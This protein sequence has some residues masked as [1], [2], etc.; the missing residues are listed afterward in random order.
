M[1]KRQESGHRSGRGQAS[2]NRRS[3]LIS[4][5]VEHAPDAVVVLECSEPAECK[6]VYANAAFERLYGVTRAQV[7]GK[8]LVAVLPQRAPPQDVAR[9]LAGLKADA[10]FR[11]LHRRIGMQGNLL[12]LEVIYEPYRTH[13][14]VF[15]VGVSRDMTETVLTQRSSRHLA[16]A[17]DEA[18][19]AIAVSIA[20]ED[21][22][23]FEY[24]NRAFTELLG[25]ETA[26]LVGRSWRSLYA[27]ETDL[28]D[29]VDYRIGL[30]TGQKVRGDM[31]LRRKDGVVLLVSVSATPFLAD[32]E[33]TRFAVAT[34]RDV[35]HARREER[36]LREQA[37]LD[38]LTGL[39]NRREFERLLQRAIEMTPASDRAHVMMFIDLDG[40]KSINDTLGHDAGDRVLIAVAEVLQRSLLPSDDVARWGGDEFAAILYFCTPEQAAVRAERLIE[41][42]ASAPECRGVGASIGIVRVAAGATISELMHHADRLVYEAKA[43]GRNR[44]VVER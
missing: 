38:A 37:A 16:R 11:V 10:P 2:G 20:R 28:K 39:R 26:E 31:L 30:L 6:I 36:R 5:I 34:L 18:Q 22:W 33:D 3:D 7:V 32:G 17:L 8:E 12:W 15:W 21:E 44:V 42:L 19:E 14:H 40:F 41:S 9:T 4:D 23:C 27:R 35:T 29:I 43:A 24:V 25:Y 1:T 13:E